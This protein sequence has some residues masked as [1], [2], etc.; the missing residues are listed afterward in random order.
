LTS[1][2]AET[3]PSPLASPAKTLKRKMKLPPGAPSPEPAA[4]LLELVA[5]SPS[6]CAPASPVW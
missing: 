1:L 5:H 3:L 2:A 6:N 4:K